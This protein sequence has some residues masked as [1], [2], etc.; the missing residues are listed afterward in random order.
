ML[1]DGALKFARQARQ[2][3]DPQT[4]GGQTDFEKL[5]E[6]TSRSQKIVL[7]L[8]TSMKAAAAPEIVEKLTALYTYI[9]QQLIDANMNRDIKAFD[10]AITRLE[11]ERKT[12][13][14][15]MQKLAAERGTTPAPAIPA[16]PTAQQ[17]TLGAYTQS[18]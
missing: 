16:T 10:E 12:W 15:L 17:A 11:Y 1:F 8:S 6:N 3:L 4:N 2:T 7:E 9:Y 5:Y 13:S 14:M 18:A